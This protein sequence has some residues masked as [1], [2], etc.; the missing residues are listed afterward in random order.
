MQAEAKGN[1]RCPCK[2]EAE[3]DLTR[4]GEKD[5]GGRDR[6]DAATSQ[7]VPAAPEAGGGKEQIL[8]R[9]SGRS[10]VLPTP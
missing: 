8:P 10:T 4:T 3:G 9:A 2:R 1:H 5:Q 6:K 7:G